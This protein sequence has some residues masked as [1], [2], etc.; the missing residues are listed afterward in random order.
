MRVSGAFKRRKRQLKRS[1]DAV[2]RGETYRSA[3]TKHHIPKSTL[4]EH[5][6]RPKTGK[7][8]ARRACLTTVEEK[9]ILDLV[10]RF[11]DKGYP[12]NRQHL[13]EAASVVII[14]LPTE[15]QNQLP[16]KNATPGNWWIRSFYSRHKE[17]LKYA[18]PRQQEG[19]RF[20]A[21]NA[22]ALTSHFAQLV[23]LRKTYCLSDSHVWNLDET[24]ISPGRDVRGKVRQRCF[25]RRDGAT[26]VQLATFSYSD[27]ITVLPSINAAGDLGPC[28]FIFKGAHLPYREVQ[29]DGKT[30]V[31]TLSTFLPR[32]A[33]V[34]MRPETASIDGDSFFD[35]AK[36]FTEHVADLTSDGRHVLLTFDACRSHMTLKALQHFRDNRVIVYALPAH[37][38]GKTQPCDVVVF[39]VFKQEI[40]RLISVVASGGPATTIDVYQ[41]CSI[42][43]KAFYCAFTRENVTAS[44]ERARMWPIDEKK[45]LAV[46]RLRDSQPQTTLLTVT[47]MEDIMVQKLEKAKHAIVGS[48]TVVNRCG[49]VDTTKGLVLTSD[50]A[51]TAAR[52]KSADYHQ[53][54]KKALEK[55]KE[56]DSIIKDQIK[57]AERARWCVRAK[58]ARKTVDQFKVSVRPLKI[59]RAIARSRTERMKSINAAEMLLA[60]H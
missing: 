60:L 3:A 53:K 12:L 1:I 20:R 33:F 19:K 34:R 50:A 57:R 9:Q 29:V 28:L 27:R 21:M 24:G 31:Q 23:E 2:K 15:R 49:F 25:F 56:R 52:K 44:F 18:M 51:L 40:N 39:G 30:H 7:Q 17:Q 45:L 37:T 46:P 5:V 41:L 22:D 11:A 43:K 58:L 26:D 10:L 42:L 13:R 35:F 16:F 8:R 47:E 4:W 6:N 55:E 36:R 59:R 48:D 38:S 14:S 54:K 32:H